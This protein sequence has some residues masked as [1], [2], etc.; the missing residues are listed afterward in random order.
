MAHL[1]A[2]P[3][4]RPRFNPGCEQLEIRLNL[5]SV[6]PPTLG[7]FELDGNATTQTT[8]DW[9]QVYN[10]AVLHPGQNTSGSIP[11]A[12]GF[13]HNVVNKSGLGDGI[14]FTGGQSKDINDVNQWQWSVG[15][16]QDK[17]NLS[18]VFAV[19]YSVPSGGVNHTVI[20]FGADRF[21]N[22]GDTT[23]GFWFFQNP[24][25][26]NPNG[27]F[28]GSHTVG[29]ILIVADFSSS[30][31]TIN[32][33]KWVGSGGDNGS[34]QSVPTNPNSLFAIVNT[35][36]TPSGGWPFVDKSGTPNNT[37][38]PGE[39]F[40]GGIDVTY[41]G[42]PNDF[43]SF[44]AE[45]RSSTS[46]TSTLSDLIV[47]STFT[48]LGADLSITKTDNNG[49][50][51]ITGAVGTVAP[52]AGET[53]TIT[54]SNNGPSNVT[55][56]GVVD[57][58]PAF[59]TGDTW[60]AT[61]SGGASG[62]SASGSGNIRDT[63]TM[64]A[65]SSITYTVTGT[66]SRSATGTLSNTATVTAP[67]GVYDPN[68][69][70]NT[71]TDN[72]MITPPNLSVTD[73]GNGTLNSTDTARFTITVSNANGAGTALG[74]VLSDSLPDSAHLNWTSDAG[75]IAGGTLT[76]SIGNLA[77]GS[78]VTIHLS[79][80]TPAG[81]S[82]TLPDTATATP[83]NG[84]AATAS[85]TDTVLAPSLS[86]TNTGNGTVN[87][88]DT[89]SFTITVTSATGAG[90]AYGVVLSDPLPAGLAWTTSA[91]TISNGT[92]IDTIGNLAAGSSVTIHVN[93]VTPS[94]YSATLTN[95][96]TATPT[97]G[98]AASA[99]ATDVVKA[100]SLSVTDTGNGTV[101]S[102]DTATFTITV[103][104]AAGA[105]T[106][107]GVILSDPLPGG[108]AWTADA[109]T[110]TGGTL[111]DTI[112]NLA[113]G[114]SV[115]IHVQAVTPSG[116]SGTLNN[117]A[118]ATPTNGSAASASATDVVKAPSLSVTKTGNGTVNSTDSASFTITVSNATGAGTAYGVV[119]N[120]PLPDSAHLSWTSDA[121]TITSGTLT[122]AIG[123]LTAGSSV[124]IHVSAVTP[125][126]YSGTLNNTATATPTNGSAASASATD[127]VK[128]PSLI[129]TNVGGGT[130]SSSDTVSFTI[131]VSD[132]VGAGTAYGVVLTDPLPGGLSWTT[133]AGT[134][135]GGTLSDT[136]GNLAAGA[137]VT[138]H[139][140]A[141]TPSGYSAT[142]S[143]TATATPTNGS[144]ASASATGMVLA[145]VLGVTE[146]GS[147]TVN[148]TDT[149]SFTITISN[150]AGA[151]TAYGVVLSDP[152]PDSAHLHWTSPAG[153]ITS[154]TLT[155]GI[156]NL[157]GGQSVTI[158]VSAS[159]SSGYN[160]TLNNT[161]TATSTNG[162]MASASATDIVKAPSLSVTKTGNGTLNSTDTA[163]FT[164]TVSNAAG[165]GTAYGVVLSD[166]LPDS[167][168]LSWTSDGGTIT[169]G[170]LSDTIGN[171]AAGSSVTIHVNSS[172]PSGYSATLRNTA[173]ATPTNGSAASGS[174]TDV[175]K[176][177]NLS[178]TETGN[179]TLNSTDTASFTITVTNAAGAGTAYGVVL[180]D[181]LPDSADLNW[182]SSAG[183]IS[184]G[185]LTD[186][187][188]S[189]M[190]GQS[191]T[192]T[193]SAPTV[194]G[195]SATLPNTATATPT[196][197][198]AASGSA[199]D[200][201]LAP[202][203]SVTKTGNGTVNS[204]DTASF[205]IVVS[206]AT[207]AGTAYGVV[208][209]D[210]LPGGLTW[211]ADGG[212]IDNG[213]FS[214]TIG[215]LAAGSRITIHVSAP[216]PSGY[217]GTLNNTATATA[218]NGSAASG[219]ASDT[220][221]APS[222]SVTKT[223]NG[224]VNSTDSAS[225]TI[226][227]S[228][229]TGA[230]TAYGVVLS[231]P[232]PDSAHLSWTSDAG[233]ITSGTLTDAIGNLAAGSSV[234]IHVNA[235]TP[236]GYSGTLPNTATATPTNGS[237]ASGSATDTVLA[238]SLSVTDTGNG[239]VSST[240][241][242]SFTITVTNAA[243]A[244]TAYGVVLSDP[245]L[246]DFANLSW[247]TDAGTITNGT[248]TD[249][250]GT[251][252]A[253]SSVTI[254]VSAVT[255]S[256]YSATL[257]DTATATPTNGSAASG[258]ATDT[259]QAPNLA[260]SETGNGTVNSTDPVSFAITVSNT[261]LGTA[262]NVNLSDPLP[263]GLSWT[264]DGGTISGG[265]LTD[266]IGSLAAGQS[267]TIHL[268]APSTA[269]YSATLPNPAT[270]T[271]SNNSPGS[272]SASATDTVLAPHLT[273]T[274]VGDPAPVNS[275]DNVHFTIVVSN[276]GA[277]TAYNVN[278]SDPL[279]DS[280]HLSWT[281]D[282]GLIVNGTT[283]TDAIGSLAAGAS[284]MIHVSASTPA[285]YSNTLTS[286]A[287]AT[288]TNNS[289]GSVTASATD[290]V[291]APHLTIT[292]VGDPAPVNS[293]DTVHFT[294]T[295]S[296]TGAGTAYNV[297]L[298][299]LL[300]DSANLSW[301]S[302]AGSVSSG[303]LTD[304]IGSLASG[305]SVTI[306]VSAS[307]PAGYSNTLTS[308]A[309]ATSTNNSPG[310][311]TASAADTVQAPHLTIIKVGDP[312]PVS[313]PNRVHFTITVSNTGAG[314]AYNV[315]L[316]DPLPDSADLIWTIQAGDPGTIS[317]GILTD[318][319]GSLA[320]GASVTIDLSAM[321]PSGYTATLSNTATAT[322]SN[323]SPGSVMAS[324]TDTVTTASSPTADL[325]IAISSA[326][327]YTPNSV[328]TYTITV[329]NNGPSDATGASVADS[330]TTLLSGVTWTSTT[331]GSA[332]VS[333]G[334]TGSGNSLGSTVNIAAGSGNSVIFTV[335]GTSDWCLGTSNLVNTATVTSPS[336]LPDPN[337][338]NNSA[339]DTLTFVVGYTPITVNS[340]SDDPSGPSSGIVTLRDA[341]SAVNAGTADSIVFAIPG[342]PTITL[343]ANLP[344]I[345]KPVNID[346][347]TQPGVKV[348]GGGNIMLDD[349][350]TVNVRD[351][352]FTDGTLKVES[353]GI[354]NVESNFGLG[355]ALGDS[356]TLNNYGSIGVCGTLL[357]G[358]STIITNY[359]GALFDV[360]NTVALGNNS[361]VFNGLN[362]TDHATIIIGGGLTLGD[363]SAGGSDVGQVYNY[364]TST[365]S[366]GGDL[367]IYGDG[368]SFVFNGVDGSAAATLTISGSLDLVGANGIVY[369]EGTSS[370]TLTGNLTLGDAGQ[371]NNGVDSSSTTS[372]ATLT[373]GGSLI[374]G[375]SGTVNTGQVN[376]YGAAS[377][378]VAGNLTLVGGG[379]V[380][381]GIEV[382]GAPAAATLTVGGNFTAGDN[383]I[384]VNNDPSALSVTGDFTLGGTSHFEDDGT[385]SVGGTFDPGTGDP[386]N[387]DV[388][389][390][391]FIALPGSS[392]TTNT[393]T[394]D[395]LAGGLVDVQAGA[396]FA[397]AG[398]GIL[399]VHGTVT[400]EGHFQSLA[401][402]LVVV[403]VSSGGELIPQGSGV[404]DIYPGTE[405]DL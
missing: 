329:T 210:P 117:T 389:S 223:G 285:G 45:T 19:A 56:A 293:T 283:L 49:G 286:T 271:S 80:S 193:V 351:L 326:P 384:V 77:P 345:D 261:G 350:S 27:T 157:L 174:A 43:R 392:V 216:T 39:F 179:G 245:P 196:N 383:S 127:V 185:T 313:S 162:A 199:T 348:D 330:I 237:A 281:S 228:N 24:V 398:E 346:G 297:N 115:T 404:I 291:L 393:A 176:A 173:S 300:P 34:L 244:G 334:G 342:T 213:T 137:S 400:V 47:D 259:V 368:G 10:D 394:W 100:P 160:A 270:A 159:T 405:E 362:T 232:L 357:G 169:G 82:A 317:G 135:S 299:D 111:S 240:D 188:G 320:S 198:S 325:A 147:G 189:L 347:N 114:S 364:G 25:S 308:T 85:A 177:P 192:I 349:S 354:L 97:N 50:S 235:V 58:M 122:D 306:H 280:A 260:I 22:N 16:P 253:G 221:L 227:V 166:P 335:T 1:L 295:V 92:L 65:G 104:N 312:A 274:K 208:L 229:A 360:D 70:N 87:S 303:N 324:T 373:V 201:V 372:H 133:D 243:G 62:F 72:D 64:P 236:S 369:N 142:L 322:S 150:T 268:N 262:Y 180:N 83:T 292:K 140:S 204:T 53:Y 68:L 134:I 387:P 91:G 21:A 287:T 327:Y 219:S 267:V 371:V 318:A 126:G 51:S 78:S 107:Y 248:L 69:A 112:G 209:S 29:D 52:G 395:V 230:G 171:L 81:Y 103:S 257:T 343:T 60:T 376:N 33:Y 54:V 366:V 170:T 96:A 2:R 302:D 319:I 79:A 272:V 37:F 214:D 89:A 128:V 28:S 254:H 323:N 26:E 44:L 146:T 123:N 57:T 15:T 131:T 73:T 403:Y 275:T 124:T 339:T 108:L 378:M 314:T 71:A 158:T 200:T 75:T 218:I 93:A 290:T 340:A 113:A 337:L 130:V 46:V 121:G 212:T 211:T 8:H 153:T 399:N 95:T 118:T 164:I 402:S 367:T 18:D 41:L 390:G 231:D 310:S 294:I 296:N 246:P 48:T 359:N 375:T 74:V 273:I 156:G 328:V 11:G 358:D 305:A 401:N 374:I 38:L 206:N 6:S 94:G 355:D 63:V 304:A 215:N 233:T 385:M 256:G 5:G 309:T 388:V 382:G 119:L 331:T 377:L 203:L 14:I 249:T 264:S 381:N 396:T 141:V 307:T 195:Y 105:G 66:V 353:N 276:T 344:M 168:H 120:D 183:T 251:L 165:A 197:G 90:T 321:T 59:F 191:V 239:T 148:S 30:V 110:I 370:V 333:A 106:A 3:R 205:T 35:V 151:G 242:V 380:T 386:A 61:Q 99:S 129:V 23:L 67:A 88:T 225:F 149:V 154:G 282:A 182:I 361:F 138:I 252:A 363:S 175:V 31:A 356:T 76:D 277:G 217:S 36:N 255:P 266:A 284:V 289:P 279:P 288:S 298:S 116:Y 9:D 84:S 167:A 397:V 391:T 332:S 222:L 161:A 20:N 365:I 4:S 311:V 190:A 155:D 258:S 144:P 13:V 172:T 102:T 55:G 109:G 263:G 86:V 143:S 178:V 101:N 32:A 136:I 234:T 125:S 301:T 352:H 132:A 226:V 278:L 265:T 241:T 17:A 224:T 98:S 42:L 139:V 40:E 202:S 250:I 181:P 186:A 247:A 379:Q 184:G 269:G 163:S 145:P 238:P 194:P 207:G 338:A 7:T 341:I 315:N 187:I 220:V 152:L 336:G 12:V 316:N